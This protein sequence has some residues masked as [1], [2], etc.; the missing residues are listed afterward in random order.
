MNQFLLPYSVTMSK[1]KAP[2][3]EAILIGGM[4]E[5]LSVSLHEAMLSCCIIP[6]SSLCFF[7]RIPLAVV[8]IKK[9]L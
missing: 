4:I 7:N 1:Q 2:I 9:T 3:H 6:L 8:V 5:V